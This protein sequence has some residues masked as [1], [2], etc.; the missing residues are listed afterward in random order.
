MRG[1]APTS[2]ARLR[3]VLEAGP[4]GERER[5]QAAPCLVRNMPQRPVPRALTLGARVYMRSSCVEAIYMAG[6][7]LC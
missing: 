4:V 3:T 6:L 7:I 2:G 5:A 1:I